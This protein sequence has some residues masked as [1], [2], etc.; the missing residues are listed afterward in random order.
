VVLK[1]EPVEDAEVRFE[2]EVSADQIPPAFLGAV[3]EGALGAAWS[4]PLMGYPMIKVLVRAVGGEHHRTDSTEV[5]F[6]AAARSAFEAACE[7]GKPQILEPVMRFEIHVPDG[8]RGGVIHDLQGRR[9]EVREVEK[10]G[11]LDILRGTVPLARMFGYTNDLR[12]L[13]QGRGAC[14]LE[15]HA[16]APVPESVRKSLFG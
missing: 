13:T 8:F 1:L 3:K 4:G 2:A 9:A 10:E 7:K 6:A 12:S 5:A 14:S 11:D 16:Y 15:P